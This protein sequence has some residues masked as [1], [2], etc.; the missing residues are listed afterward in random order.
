MATGVGARVALAAAAAAPGRIASLSLINPNLAWTGED[1]AWWGRLLA[2]YERAGRPSLGEYAAVLVDRWFGASFVAGEP[3]ILPYVDLML[4]RQD[5]ASLIP[6]LRAWLEVDLALD[7]APLEMPVLVLRGGRVPAS[8]G[9]PRLQKTYPRLRQ[10]FVRESSW[11][12][13]LEDPTAVARI[14]D[15]FLPQRFP[16]ERAFD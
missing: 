13:Q 3:W 14:L 8:P 6:A 15:A 9:G 5:P 1:L 2:G 10:A 4:R 12:P 7:P 16:G 11:Q